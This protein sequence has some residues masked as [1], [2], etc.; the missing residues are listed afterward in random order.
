MLD[1][2]VYFLFVCLFIRLFVCSKV[3]KLY[4]L[5]M[6]RMKIKIIILINDNVGYGDGNDVIALQYQ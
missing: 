2:S 4:W 1:L 3:Q 5:A 6:I